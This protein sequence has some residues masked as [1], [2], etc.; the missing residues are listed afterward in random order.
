M[1]MRRDFTLPDPDSEFLDA[2]GLPW[3][4]VSE[5]KIN[6]ILVHEVPVPDGYTT[7]TVSVALWIQ[8][9]YPVVQIDMAYFYPHLQLASRAPIAAITFQQVGDKLFQR[10]SRH[11]T[12]SNPWRP[13]VD[14][15][16]THLSC[17]RFW[18]ERELRK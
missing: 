11:R 12:A 4:A 9:G 18:L 10:W 14:G 2:L 3:E 17:V 16:S 1:V 8:P 13:G 15:V 5:G 6:W 7:S